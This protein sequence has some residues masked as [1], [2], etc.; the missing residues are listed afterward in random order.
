MRQTKKF[1]R[2]NRKKYEQ[3]INRLESMSKRFKN[4]MKMNDN[5]LRIQ[6]TNDCLLKEDFV[7]NNENTPEK[8]KRAIENRKLE[9]MTQEEF[10]DNYKS[11]MNLGY[12]PEPEK[13]ENKLIGN[14][15]R[16]KAY[17]VFNKA[18]IEN[19]EDLEIAESICTGYGISPLTIP[20]LLKKEFDLNEIEDIV[21]MKYELETDG[22]PKR[23]EN[24]SIEKL[25][26]LR[27]KCNE[28]P[29]YEFL[30]LIQ[31]VRHKFDFRKRDSQPVFCNTVLK[32][33][34]EL[35]ETEGFDN[36]RDLERACEINGF[37]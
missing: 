20:R 6:N 5:Q 2:D 18:G 32:S 11:L 1:I 10:E 8:M 35:V 21:I 24:V 19:Q 36:I 15:T 25:S 37:L 14:Y 22:S 33:L 9:G 29:F 12:I 27:K 30:D 4:L 13:D 31:R 7:Y 34:L 3:K 16:K 17:E 28:I 26:D 23:L